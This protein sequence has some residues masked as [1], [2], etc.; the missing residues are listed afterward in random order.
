MIF[1]CIPPVNGSLFCSDQDD[2]AKLLLD[3]GADP[4]YKNALGIC[5]LALC[6]AVG[7]YRVLRLLA[8][9]P[10]INLHNQ[11]HEIYITVVLNSSDP[12]KFMLF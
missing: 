4:N 1:I 3:A 9:H 7:S 11:V 12:D 5:P 2:A 8:K 10:K 6:T